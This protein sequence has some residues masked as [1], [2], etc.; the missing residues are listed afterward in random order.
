ME[1]NNR[2]AELE[3]AIGMALCELEVLERNADFPERGYVRNIFNR[4]VR[5][6]ND[7]LGCKRCEGS[8]K[9]VRYGRKELAEPN[10]VYSDCDCKVTK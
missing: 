4:T 8:G 6:L 2:I 3:Y 1:A 10:L 5:T 7:V 9:L